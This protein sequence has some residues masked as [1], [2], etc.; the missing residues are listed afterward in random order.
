MRRS[1]SVLIQVN[2]FWTTAPFL[3]PRREGPI[4]LLVWVFLSFCWC[5]SVSYSVCHATLEKMKTGDI[6]SFRWS[7][8]TLKKKITDFRVNSCCWKFGAIKVIARGGVGSV[9]KTEIR[10]KWKFWFCIFGWN[11]GLYQRYNHINVA[12]INYGI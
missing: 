10:W 6:W 12:K 2:Q 11:R 1:D 7:Y 8:G 4:S 5:L 3:D 9:W